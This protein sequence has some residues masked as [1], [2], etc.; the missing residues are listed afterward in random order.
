MTRVS[1]TSLIVFKFFYQQ[2][3]LKV[4]FC[5]AEAVGIIYKSEIRR[6][7]WFINGRE[8]SENVLNISAI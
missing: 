6:Y 7:T 1:D 3:P 4:S 2:S 5:V 8:V